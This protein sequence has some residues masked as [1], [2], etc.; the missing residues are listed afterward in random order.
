M[1]NVD[2]GQAPED[3][4]REQP[5]WGLWLFGATLVTGILLVAAMLS[6]YIRHQF[7]VSL[8]RQTTPYTQLAFT[9][10]VSLPATVVRGEAVDVSFT[11]TNNEGKPVAYRYLIS[12]G[13]GSTLQSLSS[14]GRTVAAGAMWEVDTSVVPKCAQSACRVQVSLPQQAES[15]DF[16]FESENTTKHK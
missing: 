3:L 14:S 7:A 12:S 2:I 10:A 9:R 13:S 11:I 5:N 6:P 4:Q 1:R 8:T 16:M 15:I